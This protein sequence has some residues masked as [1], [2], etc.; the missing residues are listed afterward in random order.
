MKPPTAMASVTDQCEQLS[1]ASGTTALP[2]RPGVFI[3]FDVECSMGGAWGNPALKPVRPARAIWGEYDGQPLGLPLIV[4]ILRKH[5]L[6]GTFFVEAFIEEQGYPG[7]AERVCTYLLDHGQDVQLH[8]HPNH[9]HYGMMRRGE[10]HPRNDNIADLP[11]EAQFA[12]LQ[13]G[14]ERLARWTGKQ[15]AAFR[16]GNMGASE[17][18]LE[19]LAEAGILIDSSYTFPYAGGQCRFSPADPY[20]G[21]RWYGRVLELALSAFRQ[22]QLPLLQ[23]AKPLDLVGISFQECRDGIRAICDAGADAVLIL[24]SFSLFKWRNV[25]YDGGRINRIVTSRFRRMCGWLAG[26]ADSCPARTFSEVAEAVV[27]GRYEAKA[28]P[29]CVLRRPIRSLARKGVQAWN[30]FHWT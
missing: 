6:A 28:V 26:H 12:L 27:Q 30:S 24:H 22:P 10:P 8:I 29:P 20:N 3:T 25:Q 13:E 15:T 14:A 9:K 5:D 23:P 7:E 11:P 1:P 2:L 21:S 4:D 18:T 16:A 19:Q 17:E